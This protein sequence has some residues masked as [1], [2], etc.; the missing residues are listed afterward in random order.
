MLEE[1]LTKLENQKMT[2][3]I[4]THDVDFAYRWADRAVVFC[5]GKIIADGTPLEVFKR[6]D[7]LDKANLKR[8][9]MLDVYEEMVAHGLVADNN[10]YPKTVAQ[11][12]EMLGNVDK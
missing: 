5:G 9:M 4:S 12:K 2:L 11:F 10:Y 1:A 6:Q 7:I 3:L 8:P